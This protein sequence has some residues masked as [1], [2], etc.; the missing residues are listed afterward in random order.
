VIVDNEEGADVDTTDPRKAH[1]IAVPGRIVFR[2]PRR[3]CAR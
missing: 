3:A 2:S 1:L